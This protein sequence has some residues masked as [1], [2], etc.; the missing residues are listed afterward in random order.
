M[1]LSIE[2][3]SGVPGATSYVDVAEARAYADARGL[4]LPAADAD[5]EIALTTSGDYLFRYEKDYKGARSNF[6][7]RMSFPRYPVYLNNYRIASDEIPESLKVAQILL[8]IELLA[9][10]DLRPDGEGQ[11]TLM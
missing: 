9:C 7:Q 4:S 11:E 5:V 2:D 8:C 6:D 10:T 3:G 1:A